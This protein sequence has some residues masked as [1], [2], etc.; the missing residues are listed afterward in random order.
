MRSCVRFIAKL[1]PSLRLPCAERR[2]VCPEP[3]H[4]QPVAFDRGSKRVPIMAEDDMA[5]RVMRLYGLLRSTGE[6]HRKAAI[7]SEIDRLLG[8]LQDAAR[9]IQPGA[10]PTEQDERQLGA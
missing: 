6:E 1:P 2:P 4:W 3:A 7:R 8:R 5:V 10:A 9:A